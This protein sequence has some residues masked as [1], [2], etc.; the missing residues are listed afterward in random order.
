MQQPSSAPG[1]GITLTLGG[2]TPFK[3]F[4]IKADGVAI[5]PGSESIAQAVCGGVGHNSPVDKSAVAVTLPPGS[6]GQRNVQAYVLQGVHS[7]YELSLR[8]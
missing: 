6:T 5:A 3:G 8:L 7:W 1:G 2:A 4:L